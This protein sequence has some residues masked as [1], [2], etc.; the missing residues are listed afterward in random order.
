MDNNYY[1][2]SST[3]YKKVSSFPLIEKD[4]DT[5][6]YEM[7]HLNQKIDFTM[8]KSNDLKSSSTKFNKALKS[9]HHKDFKSPRDKFGDSIILSTEHFD[10]VHRF[11][12]N[13][14]NFDSE[15]NMFKGSLS[16]SYQC[17]PL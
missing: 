10:D 8:T 5:N 3:N 1:P 12:F 7:I 13:K 9:L 14:K 4:F 16:F 17:W 11:L 6:L 2:D 15:Y